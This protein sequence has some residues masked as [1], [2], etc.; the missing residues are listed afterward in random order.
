M[1][2]RWMIALA[3]AAHGI[4]AMAQTVYESKDKAGPVFSDRPSAGA[5]AVELQAPNVVSPPAATPK[6]VPPPSAAAPPPYR[7]FVVARPAEQ[8]TVHT[9]TGEFGISANLTPP[10]RPGDRVRVLLDGNLLPGTYRST[11]LRISES[12]W[13][14]A[15]VGHDGEH[16]LQLAVVGAD[17]KPWIESEP[18]RF[19]VRRAAVGGTRR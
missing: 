10:L 14:S 2:R 18:V 1:T 11:Q 17:G 13:Q 12:D 5:S 4:A 16:T 6:P 15:A 19:Y 9:N 8:T 3:L 7:R